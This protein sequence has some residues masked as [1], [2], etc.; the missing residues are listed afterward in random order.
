MIDISLSGGAIVSGVVTEHID[1]PFAPTIDLKYLAR[2][3][4]HICFGVR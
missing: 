4:Y 2:P 3:W 1:K